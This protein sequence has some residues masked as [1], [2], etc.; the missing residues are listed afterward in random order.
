M[1]IVGKLPVADFEKIPSSGFFTEALGTKVR[2]SLI[3]LSEMYLVLE[4]PAGLS[5]ASFGV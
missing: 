2:D 3:Y 1:Y 4:V 5:A